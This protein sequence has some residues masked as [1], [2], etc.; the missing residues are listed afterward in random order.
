M[1]IYSSSE[2][3]FKC[4]FTPIRSF[5]I[6]LPES[7][8]VLMMARGCAGKGPCQ[9]INSLLKALH[10]FN[11]IKTLSAHGKVKQNRIKTLSLIQIGSFFVT[12][13][14]LVCCFRTSQDGCLHLKNYLQI[15][16]ALNLPE[17]KA[18]YWEDIYNIDLSVSI[19]HCL[20][21]QGIV[22]PPLGPRETYIMF[23]LLPFSFIPL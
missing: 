20:T 8:R 9:G 17:M 16:F 6:S 14:P 13:Y 12:T 23:S 5:S 1:N 19:R 2:S 22:G 7:L 21:Y 11:K 10:R 18:N 4:N 3:V 15:N